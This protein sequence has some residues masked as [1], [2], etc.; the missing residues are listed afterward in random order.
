MITPA[1]TFLSDLRA[2]GMSAAEQRRLVAGL[3]RLAPGAYARTEGL[4]PV[5][6]H[7]ARASAVLG[8]VS[9]VVA[10][11]TTAAVAWGLPLLDHHLGTVHVSRVVGRRGGAK[12]GRAHHVHSREVAGE[13]IDEQAGM[14]CTS[15]VLTVLDCARLLDQD[16]GV[17]IADAALHTGIVSREELVDRAGAVIHCT[18]A[19]RARV[20]PT[21]TSA[22]AESPGE[23]LLRRRLNRMGF[24]P[25]EQV[26]IG[27]DRVDFLIDDCLVVEFDGRGKYEL[28]GDPAAAHWAEKRRNDRLVEMGYEV[29]HVTWADLWDEAAL[30]TRIARSLRRAHGRSGHYLLPVG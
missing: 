2:Q 10:S 4:D 1:I 5:A 26:D 19:G 25:R 30:A 17:A 29:I 22:M 15:P 18:G 9:G 12:S 24:T 6:V 20:L 3:D 7:L 28:R 11:H 27:G 8:R 21:M 23:S 14:P 16:W 13:D